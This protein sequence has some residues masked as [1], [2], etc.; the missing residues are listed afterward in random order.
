M[1]AIFSFIK[2]E[3][4]SAILVLLS[5]IPLFFIGSLLDIFL[6]HLYARTEKGETALPVISQWVHDSIAGHRLLPQEIMICFWVLMVLLFIVN[7]LTAGDQQQFRI[8]FIYSFLFTWLLSITTASFIAL[9]C[10]LPFDLLLSRVGEGDMFCSLFRII[11][12][13][14]LTLIVIIPAGVLIWTRTRKT[15]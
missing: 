4:V 5:F 3:F 15:E 10:A 11:L 6:T 12:L 7:A 14:E 13:F 9:A 2:R 8:R 1:K